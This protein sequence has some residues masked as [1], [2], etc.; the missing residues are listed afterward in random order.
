MARVLV[1]TSDRADIFSRIYRRN[2][3][4]GEPGYFYSGGGGDEPFSHAYVSFVSGFLAS[5]GRPATL[6]DIG[7]GDYRV[8]SRITA[9]GLRYIGVD[10]VPEL[11][12]HNARVYGS[13][14]VDFRCLDVVEQDPPAG[15]VCLIRQV[16]QHLSNTD[17]TQILPRLEQYEYVLVTEHLPDV[18]RRANVNMWTGAAT[19][20]PYG[21]GVCLDQ[22]P[23]SVQNVETVLAVPGD[24]FGRLVTT[25]IRGRSK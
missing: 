21:S 23:F 24:Q 7:C 8:S 2:V 13:K 17:I 6:V 14:S 20:S 19:R 10:I 11:I 5:L 9:S 3:W 12:E 22:P 18:I 4:G 16:L 1:S 25:L 15:D